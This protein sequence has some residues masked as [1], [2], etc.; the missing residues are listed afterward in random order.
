MTS[1]SSGIVYLVGAGPGDPE[2]ITVRGLKCL[3]RADVVVYDRL[4]NRSL[5]DHAPAGAELIDVGKEADRHTMPQE[6]I[7]RLLVEKGR[8]G[9]TVVRLK[10]GDPFVFGRGGEE[11]L[12][13]A[14]AGVPFEVVPGI[15]SA[16][17]APAY[18][19]IPVTH[20]GVAGSVTIVT[21]HRAD[22]TSDAEATW[23]RLAAASDGTLVFL[24]GVGNLPNIVAALRR[25]GR[26]A[27]TPV[28]LIACGTCPEQ[29][30][31]IGTLAD[32]GERAAGI[33]RPP[34]VIV[35][36]EVVALAEK[37]AWFRP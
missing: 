36:G 17:A 25:G 5:L 8:A 18:A 32:I 2:L 28:A 31:V 4:A 26:P 19:G 37:L 3:Q 24:M 9:K 16:I 30:T 34:A 1:S 15:T 33:I 13:L 11:A 14:E 23:E 27:D 21:G 7:N 22:A 35:V 20:R 29:Q 10:G 12:A 6:E